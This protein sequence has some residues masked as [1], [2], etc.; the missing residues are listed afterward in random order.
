MRGFVKPIVVLSKCLE[1]EACRYDGQVI[2]DG[3]VKQLEPHVAFIPVCPEVEI[4][5]GVPREP[6]QIVSVKGEQRLIQ[7]AT[8]K[9]LSDAMPSFA[10]R[11]LTSLDEVDGFI[12][13]S[14][15]PSSG[16]KDVKVYLGMEK[17]AATRKSA[18]FFARKVLERFPGLAIE[19][20]G[21][22]TNFK[23]REHFLTKLFALASLRATKKS[24]SMGALIRF[25]TVNKLLL[26]A[27]NQKEMRILGKIVANHEKN[28]TAEVMA[29]YEPHFK[30]ALAR[31]SKSSSAVNVLMH[32]LGYFSKQLSSQEKAF[33]LEALEKYRRGKIP[34]SAPL[35]ILRAWIIRFENHYLMEQ[36]F[37]EPYPMD[38]QL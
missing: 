32:G 15:S 30:A 16:I 17:G 18:G 37:F 11:F 25:H 13:K 5:L 1:F 26:M 6:I 19:D 21:R 8:G 4:G 9:D 29:D 2:P 12:L 7:R 23:I 35:S 10:D 14:R 33:F 3:F 36:T 28:P 24:S 27:Y 22:L 20:E 31:A 38:I 34:L